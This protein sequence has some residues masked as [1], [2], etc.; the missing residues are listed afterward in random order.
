MVYLPTLSIK[1]QLNV[2]TYAIHGSLGREIPQIYHTFAF[3]VD[4]P[5]KWV[6]M[7]H[8][9]CSK[10]WL[11]FLDQMLQPTS[12]KPGGAKE[13]LGYQ[14]VDLALNQAAKPWFHQYL[15]LA[16]GTICGGLFS[17]NVFRGQICSLGYQPS[18][19]TSVERSRK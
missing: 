2:D 10:K 16:T 17:E 3:E 15:D 11:S 6:P 12:R 5:Q 7:G 4:F 8:H 14:V 9:P 19:T 1:N 13:L 18:K